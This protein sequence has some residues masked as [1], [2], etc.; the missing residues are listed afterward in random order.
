MAKLS[1]ME[2]K[3][4]VDLG[5]VK[6]KTTRKVNDITV[7]TETI[8]HKEYIGMMHNKHMELIRR[9]TELSSNDL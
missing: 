3:V 8:A 7:T 6:M 1:K 5:L 4:D 9:H 2:L